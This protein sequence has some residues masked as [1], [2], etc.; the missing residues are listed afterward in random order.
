MS[1]SQ[2]SEEGESSRELGDEAQTGDGAERQYNPEQLLEAEPETYTAE[3]LLMDEGL[4][5]K[6][7]RQVQ[8]DPSHFLRA[9]FYQQLEQRQA[10]VQP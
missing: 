2:A 1:E 9:K 4:R 6:W 8:P 7:M 5:E 10:E 3:Q